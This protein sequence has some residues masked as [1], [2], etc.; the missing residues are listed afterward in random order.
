MPFNDP[1]PGT[2]ETV[3]GMF[4]AENKVWDSLGQ[5]GWGKLPKTD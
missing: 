5:E 2:R 4:T 3:V 1:G